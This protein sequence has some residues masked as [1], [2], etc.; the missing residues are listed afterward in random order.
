M[1]TLYGGRLRKLA[2]QKR[3]SMCQKRP[4]MKTLYGG[5]LRKLASRP[6]LA[7]GAHRENTFYFRF[8]T[9]PPPLVLYIYIYN[10]QVYI[11]E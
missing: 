3:P 9:L 10:I 8:C 5:R 2:S 11:Y 7:H 6:G 1:K 4:S